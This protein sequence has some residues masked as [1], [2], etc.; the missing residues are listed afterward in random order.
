MDWMGRV[1]GLDEAFLGSSGKGGGVI[2]V[3]TV[4]QGVRLS[5]SPSSWA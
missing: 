1:L 4:V 5:G 2:G 3:S